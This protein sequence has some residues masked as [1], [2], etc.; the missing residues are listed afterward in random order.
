MCSL[1]VC[2]TKSEHSASCSNLLKVSF[3]ATT[4]SSS[5]RTGFHSFHDKGSPTFSPRLSSSEEVFTMP[6]PF[7]SLYFSSANIPTTTT[8]M[9]CVA[10]ESSSSLEA[11]QKILYTTLFEGTFNSIQFLF[12]CFESHTKLLGR[13]YRNHCLYILRFMFPRFLGFGFRLFLL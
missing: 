4:N 13:F 8:T 3:T 11:S 7:F 2:W 10:K 6:S 12:V 1:W 5:Y 9:A